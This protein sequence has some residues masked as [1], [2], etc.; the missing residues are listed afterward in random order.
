MRMET[1]GRLP[2]TDFK[3]SFVALYGVVRAKRGEL[4]ALAVFGFL[5]VKDFLAAFKYAQTMV[6]TSFLRLVVLFNG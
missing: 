3:K 5:M 1:A 6:T 2:G 4:A